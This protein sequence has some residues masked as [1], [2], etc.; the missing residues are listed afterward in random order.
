MCD[1]LDRDLNLGLDLDMD[2]DLARGLP[3][4]LGRGLLVRSWVVVRDA[5]RYLP[6]WA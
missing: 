3:R 4:S 2:L 5:R 1:C 6:R